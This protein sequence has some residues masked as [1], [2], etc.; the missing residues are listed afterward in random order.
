MKLPLN[1]SQ[2]ALA[3]LNIANHTSRSNN[4]ST[5]WSWMTCVAFWAAILDF[6]VD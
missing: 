5:D 3:Q 4:I 1:Q 6:D 2:V